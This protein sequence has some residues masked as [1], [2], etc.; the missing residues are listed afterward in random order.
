MINIISA[1]LGRNV[2]KFHV[3]LIM[4]QY[5]ALLFGSIGLR[6]TSEQV[7]RFEEAKNF[8]IGA[9]VKDLG[10]SP[11]DFEHGLALELQWLGK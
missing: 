5:A 1:R 2:K 9:A 6:I 7:L 10:Y 11:L 4:A 8:D 3:P